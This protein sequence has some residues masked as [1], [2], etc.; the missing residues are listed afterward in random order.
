MNPFDLP[1]FTLLDIMAGLSII[2]AIIF[3]YVSIR[4]KRGEKE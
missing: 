4:Y 2:L 3:T 1:F